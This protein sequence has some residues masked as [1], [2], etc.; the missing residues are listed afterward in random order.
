MKTSRQFYIV[1]ADILPE[2][3]V[4]TAQAKELLAKGEAETIN[5]AV[6]RVE[7]SRSA[8]Y[9]Y[10]DGIF[11]F[12]QERRE[13]IVTLNMILDHRLGV[14][15]GVINTIA[16]VQGNILTINQSIPLQNMANVTLSLETAQMQVTVPELLECFLA[17]PGVLKVEL[18]G[19]SI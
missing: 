4:K 9:K 2:A 13:Q 7:L 17:I 6:D 16:T 15:S 5:Q 3:M 1:S 11:P 14:L 19:Q 10:R 12:Y 18:V 8:F